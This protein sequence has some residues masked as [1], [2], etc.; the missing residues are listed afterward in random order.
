[1]KCFLKLAAWV[2]AIELLGALSG[3]MTE[4]G[5]QVW[6]QALHK[7]ILTPPDMVFPIVWGVLYAMIGVVGWLIWSAQTTPHSTVV[8]RLYVIQL[9]L[10]LSW[11]PLF[12]HFHFVGASLVVVAAILLLVVALI[13]RLSAISRLAAGL[14][15]PYALW[16][17]LATYLNYFIWWHN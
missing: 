12:F 17:S 10:N 3:L 14:L 2:V 5:L 7:S 13:V 15:V 4:G 1:M 6:Y 16:L 8:R 11:T 9:L